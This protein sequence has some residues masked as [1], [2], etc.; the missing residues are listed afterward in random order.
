MGCTRSLEF[1]GDRVHGGR[2][3]TSVLRTKMAISSVLPGEA[4]IRCSLVSLRTI[5]GCKRRQPTQCYKRSTPQA[6]PEGGLHCAC[7]HRISR[8]WPGSL[9]LPSCSI[10]TESLRAR[11]I[12][13]RGCEKYKKARTISSSSLSAL[14]A[15]RFLWE[16][17]D[18]RRLG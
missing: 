4:T 1:P 7:A 14:H 8:V 16:R 12:Q 15:L 3:V 10:G 13:R 6:Y 9:A 11:N 18:A 5:R 17:L 2:S